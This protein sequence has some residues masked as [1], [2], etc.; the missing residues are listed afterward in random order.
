M[1]VVTHHAVARNLYLYFWRFFWLST[2]RPVV[3][4]KVLRRGEVNLEHDR[5]K[6]IIT[7]K[8]II[9]FICMAFTR[10]INIKNAN[11]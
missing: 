5:E 2:V 6:I 11:I 10:T 4:M 8:T 1:S 9:I 7:I 3:G